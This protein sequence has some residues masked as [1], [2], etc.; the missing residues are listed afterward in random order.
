[1][2]DAVI[3]D[4]RGLYRRAKRQKREVSEIE[5]DSLMASAE[6]YGVTKEVKKALAGKPE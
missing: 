6:R 1:M 2:G 3:R 4:A 5:R